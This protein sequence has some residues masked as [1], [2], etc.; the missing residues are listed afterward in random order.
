MLHGLARGYISDYCVKVSTNQRRSSLHSAS[1]NRLLVPPPSKTIKFG[2]RAFGISSPP[3]PPPQ[4]G[5]L[6]QS[7]YKFYLYFIIFKFIPLI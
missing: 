6:C 1:H 2:E 5:T 4:R 3:P 7:V